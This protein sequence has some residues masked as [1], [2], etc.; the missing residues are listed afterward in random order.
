MAK[1]TQYWIEAGDI[2]TNLPAQHNTGAW[3]S[4]DEI[5]WDILKCCGI[6]GCC[7]DEGATF[8]G[9]E[10]H[11]P[12]TVTDSGSIDFGIT[13]QDIT[14]KITGITSATIGKVPYKVGNTNTGLIAWAWAAIGALPEYVDNAAATAPGQLVPGQ[15]YHTAGVV[16]IVL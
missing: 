1:K 11:A 2:K 10:S 3:R 14:A 8:D 13:G 15:F 7:S 12:A 16:K 6:E 5:V 9:F 4:L